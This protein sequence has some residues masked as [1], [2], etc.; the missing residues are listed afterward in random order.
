MSGGRWNYGQCNLG[1]DMYPNSE[2]RYG[3]GENTK[4]REYTKSVK[5]ARQ[6]N[7]MCDKQISELVYDVLCLIYSCD[8]Y[9]SG[10]TGEENYLEDVQFF[11]KK[12]LKIKPEDAVRAEIDKSVSET[13]DELYKN[14][15]ISMDEKEVLQQ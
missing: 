6:A 1:Y 4:Y 3:L 10:D 8:W 15:G 2:V 9:L 14:F 5:A 12:W 13:K 11:K 7:P